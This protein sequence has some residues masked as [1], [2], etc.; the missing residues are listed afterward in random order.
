MT[1]HWFYAV[2]SAPT[3]YS[4]GAFQHVHDAADDAA[5]VR[6]LDRP[7]FRPTLE[8]TEFVSKSATTFAPLTF[9]TQYD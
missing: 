1:I 7:T 5:I 6:P 8:A 9:V 3:S 2:R 4:D